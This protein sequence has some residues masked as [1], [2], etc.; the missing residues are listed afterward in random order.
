[1]KHRGV[2]SVRRH[3]KQGAARSRKRIRVGQAG[4]VSRADDIL[5]PARGKGNVWAVLYTT[6]RGGKE[7]RDRRSVQKSKRF[8]VPGRYGVAYLLQLLPVS[9][10][11]QKVTSSRTL[12]MRAVFTRTVMM[13][14]LGPGD[15]QGMRQGMCV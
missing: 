15:R 14:M 8:G 10:T 7:T 2:M 4:S 13:A 9:A 3:I 12:H 5:N 1:M 6:S 11:S